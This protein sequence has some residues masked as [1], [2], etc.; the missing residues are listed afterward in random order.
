[1]K[2]STKVTILAVALAIT[3]PL[4]AYAATLTSQNTTSSTT[5]ST[6]KSTAQQSTADVGRHGGNPA[7]LGT[8]LPTLLKLDQATLQSKLAAGSTLLEIAKAQNVTEAQLKETLTSAFTKHQATEKT[9]FEA[10]L[11]TLINSKQLGK[12]NDGGRGMGAGRGP[13]GQHGPGEQGGPGGNMMAPP[14]DSA[15]PAN[16]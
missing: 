11:D 15:A 3:I 12:M 16:N 13:G 6:T 14:A 9:Q 7:I 8:E 5:T 1:M 2:K 4:S 10:N